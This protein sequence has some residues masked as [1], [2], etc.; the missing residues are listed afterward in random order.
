VL[1]LLQ[2][3]PVLDSS[4]TVGRNLWRSAPKR[5]LPCQK[6]PG[7]AVSDAVLLGRLQRRCGRERFPAVQQNARFRHLVPTLSNH[8]RPVGPRQLLSA[9]R[10]PRHHHHSR[11]KSESCRPGQASAL[12]SVRTVAAL[13]LSIRPQ[14]MSRCVRLRLSGA[15]TS[16][17]LEGDRPADER[18]PTADLTVPAGRYPVEL[19][20]CHNVAVSYDTDRRRRV[21]HN[22]HGGRLG[23]S[24]SRGVGAMTVRAQAGGRMLASRDD[25]HDLSI[26]QGSRAGAS[27][28]CRP[29][30]STGNRSVGG[31]Q[32]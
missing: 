21:P 27:G 18:G 1:G 5:P 32:P 17:S 30:R 15:Q 19:V 2:I 4:S 28:A 24:G 7:T 20:E 25:P 14:A 29:R 3:G 8:L 26:I 23:C 11:L 16:V 10:K 6:R 12:A 22:A 31:V 9:L 13:P